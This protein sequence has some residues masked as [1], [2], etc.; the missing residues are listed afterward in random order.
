MVPQFDIYSTGDCAT[1]ISF[2]DKMN[3]EINDRVLQVFTYLKR[4]NRYWV[5][6]LP[7]YS[8]VTV[9]FDVVALRQMGISEPYRFVNEKLEE[10]AGS[11]LKTDSESKRKITIPVCYHSSFATDYKRV[12]NQ[13][14]ISVEE[15]VELHSQTPYRVFMIG[16]LPGF[17]Y[18]GTLNKKLITPRLEKP[19]ANV[20]EGSVGIAGS[21]TGIYPLDSPGGW[22]IIGRTPIKLFDAGKA[23]QGSDTAI[24]FQPTDEVIFKPIS[25]ADFDSFDSLLF[26]PFQS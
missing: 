15:M 2:G 4:E 9:F 23:K 16:F 20:N 5:D 14:K 24:L 19:H 7:A 13:N 1:T 6:V 18:M 26:N 25:K 11:I 21:Q 8:S 3:S 10:A 22:N 17:A 12:C